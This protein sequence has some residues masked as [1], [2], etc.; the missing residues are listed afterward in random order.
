MRSILTA[1]LLLGAAAAGCVQAPS[2]AVD[3]AAAGAPFAPLVPPAPDFDFS[4]VVDADHANHQLPALHE[5]GHGLA[6]KGH[7]AIGHI[8]PPGT[9]GS[10]TQVDVWGDYAVVS[11]MEGGLA[12][13]IVDIADPAAPKAVSWWPSAADGWTARFSDDGDFVFYGCQ[14]FPAQPGLGLA[15]NPTAHLVGTCEDPSAPHLPGEN[16]AGVVVVD[17]TDKADPRFVH[18]LPVGGSH[19]LFAANVNGTDYV[20]TASTAILKFDRE[21]MQLEVV[22]EVPGVHDATVAKHP[23]TGDWL[24]F[25]G[26]EQLTI[27]EVNDPANPQVVYEGKGAESEWVGWHEQTLVPGVVDGRVVLAVAGETFVSPQGVPDSV[28]FVDVTDPANPALLSEWKPPF[29]SKV[30][31]AGYLY[32]VHEMAATPTG[33]VAVSWYHGGVWVLDVSTQERQAGPVTLA[34][35]LPHEVVNVA[36]STFTQTAVPYVPF[37]WGAGWK[38]DGHL[39]VPDMHTGLYVLE[40]DWG[41][42][43]A[44]DGGQ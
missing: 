36:P 39:V 35:Y 29:E 30:P 34:A 42:H 9:R 41:L 23:I 32:S 20:F 28:F 13:A 44:A 15:Y 3:A 2:D 33:Q 1:I 19:N 14:M 25:T 4:A 16:E 37:V 24:L 7:A 22:A 17:V 26:T 43:P 6:L 40:P 11:G 21:K 8:L 18:F 12:F 10:I 27:Y 38:A 5:G 31:W